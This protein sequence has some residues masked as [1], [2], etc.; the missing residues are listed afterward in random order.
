MPKLQISP[1]YSNENGILLYQ[2]H[3]FTFLFEHFSVIF[4]F[5]VTGWIQ[6][7]YKISSRYFAEFLKPNIKTAHFKNRNF[8]KENMW[9]FEHPLNPHIKIK[10]LRT[11]TVY[12][13]MPSIS[14]CAIIW[15]SFSIFSIF[16]C[17]VRMHLFL[18]QF[19]FSTITHKTKQNG[20][21]WETK[22]PL[23]GLNWKLK[24]GFCLL[25]R[26]LGQS[27]SFVVQLTIV[28]MKISGE[29]AKICTCSI[30]IHN[31]NVYISKIRFW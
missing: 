5:K 24:Q 18:V 30:I 11:K 12:R 1:N 31:A 13:F 17:V 29:S 25:F 7:F 6:K 23:F 9:F 3:M 14:V 2:I 19:Q 10:M 20:T 4:F 26:K 8:S 22:S 21:K 27:L 15:N 28:C 16:W